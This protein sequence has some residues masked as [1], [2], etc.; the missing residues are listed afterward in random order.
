[1]QFCKNVIK[2]VLIIIFNSVEKYGH[3]IGEWCGSSLDKILS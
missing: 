3:G 2:I 1:M